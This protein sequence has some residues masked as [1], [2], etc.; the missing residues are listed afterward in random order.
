MQAHYEAV[1]ST[2][3]FLSAQRDTLTIAEAIA[4][5]VAAMCGRE[6][7]AAKV[8]RYV[9]HQL[10]IRGLLRGIER[11]DSFGHVATRGACKVWRAA[12][13]GR[14]LSAAQRRYNSRRLLPNL[15][16]VFVDLERKDDVD[17][18]LFERDM[19][20]CT[21]GVEPVTVY[22]EGRANEPTGASNAA[23]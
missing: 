22:R 4:L 9:F 3:T 17:Y 19:L 23:D 21:Y 2:V 5:S 7:T 1:R 20:H 11:V 16:L 8:A 18:I 14:R 15:E 10:A 13:Y 12:L 6:S